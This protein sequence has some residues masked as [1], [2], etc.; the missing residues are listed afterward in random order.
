MSASFVRTLRIVQL[1]APQPHGVSSYSCVAYISTI[2]SSVHL[3]FLEPFS[4]YS[5]LF[6]ILLCN[7]QLPSLPQNLI[8][9][10]KLSNAT[11]LHWSSP[12]LCCYLENTSQQEARVIVLTSSVY[13]SQE[14]Q[15]CTALYSKNTIVSFFFFNPVFYLFTVEGKVQHRLLY[16]GRSRHTCSTY[17]FCLIPS[18][19]F[20]PHQTTTSLHLA[21]QLLVF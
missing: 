18:P 11:I 7:F 19:T 14:S 3:R 4:V 20:S 1:I 16:L 17:P 8:C 9:L 10:L 21:K 2:H 15:S 13:L 6:Q 5:L 12:F